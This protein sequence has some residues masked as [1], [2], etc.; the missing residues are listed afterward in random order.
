MSY[1]KI[2]DWSNA[3]QGVLALLALLVSVVSALPLKSIDPSFARSFWTILLEIFT[4]KIEMPVYLLLVLCLV[5][6]LYITKLKKRYTPKG[7]SEIFLIGTWKNEWTINGHTDS[8]IFN[9]TK[10][11][12]YVMNNEHIFTIVDFKHNPLV[13]E[14]TFIKVGVRPNDNRKHLN[15]LKILNNDVLIGVE[16]QYQIKYTKLS[17]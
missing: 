13:N 3:N 2:K 10:D 17:N 6:F 16:D 15:K 4:L 7:V 5:I 11:L 9:I 14:I 1:K 8:E 12:H